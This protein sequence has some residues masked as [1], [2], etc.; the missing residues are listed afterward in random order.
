VHRN[1]KKQRTKGKNC[2][3]VFLLPS[4][5]VYFYGMQKVI[6]YL[7]MSLDGYIADMNGQIDWLTSFPTPPS[8]DFGYEQ[9]L[10]EASTLI[11][12]RKTYEFVVNQ[13]GE[14]PY[15]GKKTWIISKNPYFP[16]QSPNT[17]V[18]LLRYAPSLEEMLSDNSGAI[19]LVG[20]AEVV[21]LFLQKK[22][23]KEL[24][25]ILVPI[26]LGHGIQLFTPPFPKTFWELTKVQSYDNGMVLLHYLHKVP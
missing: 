17:E 7:A 9:L 25:I 8:E 26:T 1:Y 21:K 15:T 4:I 24:R 23:I 11:M 20:G 10:E 14:W 3:F 13:P 2:S 12:G 6:A 16:I 18:V 22:W 5:K 19:W